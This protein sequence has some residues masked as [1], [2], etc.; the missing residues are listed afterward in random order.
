MET[1]MPILSSFLLA[2]IPALFYA[3]I[4][5]WLD[6]YEKEP[7]RLIFGS[8]IWGAVIAA[9][10]AYIINTIFGVGV[11]LITG[12]EAITEI[13]TGSLSAPF[14]EE[15][16]K[17]FAVLIVFLFFRN[18]L[19]SILD[20]IVYAAITALGFA[21][22]ENMLYMYQWG[23]LEDGW[24]GLW[25]V[26]FLRVILNAWSHASYTSFTGIG[27]A[28]ARLAKQ[29][30]VKFIAPLA[31]LSVAIFIH[32]LHNTF[33]AFVESLGGMVLVYLSDWLG[34]LFIFAIIIW[35]IWQERKWIE[36]QLKDEIS[37]G[38]LTQQQFHVALSPMRRGLAA[39]DGIGTGR[40]RNTR[41]FYKLVIE[42][43]FLKQ[44]ASITAGDP[45][46][47]TISIEK[48]RQDVK[49]LSDE[50]I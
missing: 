17:G 2:F 22:T 27:L 46:K 23:Y 13:A 21:A 50:F 11:Y 19:D 7:K 6:R 32:F 42:L 15:I 3:G 30:A 5:F 45:T 35:A 10:A 44:H 43:A 24:E 31:G 28:I 39:V 20:G 41:K 9:G 37:G 33:L 14:V 36:T 18:E 12:D 25:A 38:L 26:F 47:S 16:L 34:W 4:V 1:N 29:T 48:L 49:Q 8:F 40:F